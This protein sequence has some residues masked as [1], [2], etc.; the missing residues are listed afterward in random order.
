VWRGCVPWAVAWAQAALTSPQ[1]VQLGAVTAYRARR[2]PQDLL[3]LVWFFL[4][5]HARWAVKGWCWITHGDLRADARAA[6]LAGDSEVRRGA[7]EM[8][9]A[10]GHARWA[11]LGHSG[12]LGLAGGLLIAFLAGV[13][14][15]I[16]AQ[17]PREEMWPWLATLYTLLGVLA[18][19][20]GWLLKAAP[21]GWVIAAVWE[22]RDRTPGAGWLIR[23]SREDA[24]SWVDERMISQALAH[25][26]IAPLDRFV[27]NG[28]ELTYTVPA[29]VDGDGTYAQIRLPLGVEADMV[30]ARRK[31]LA[32]NLGRAALETWPTEGDEAG[33]LELWIAD[34][35]RLG[36]GAGP[37]PLLHEGSVDVFTGVPIGRTQRGQVIHGLFFERNW[38]VGGRPGQGKT[39]LVRI[40]VLGAGLDPTAEIWVFVIAQN[41]DF[42]P[43]APRLS[44]YAV[45]MGPEVAAAAVQALADLL[46]EMERRGKL[47]ATLPG[48]PPA[49]SRRLADKPALRLHPLICV[50]SECHE[51]FGHSTYGAQAAKLAISVIKQGRK[52]G[53]T[54]ILDTQSPTA[55][56]IP[57]DVT[58]HISCGIAFSVADHDANDGLLGSGK[59]RAGIRA[60]ELRM[61]TDRGTCVAVGVSDA[62]FELLN[63]F[64][65]PYTDGTDLVTP[66][67]TRAMAAIHDLRRTG[68]PT[69]GDEDQ[70]EDGSAEVDHLANIHQ[71]LR[72]ER[73]VRTQV[74]LSRLAELDP[75]TYEG[76]GFH[77]LTTT[78]ARHGIKP[79]KSRGVKSI[80]AADITHA[81]THH[82][83]HNTT[84]SDH[85]KGT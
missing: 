63:T 34:K 18:A 9:R 69:T 50:I 60:T 70:D 41:T 27:K 61:N 21:M 12:R 85:G 55:A 35:G 81:L 15:L 62:T 23:P 24:D 66:V 78:L 58:R 17:V 40:L 20:G 30:A 29:R 6:R 28:G 75:A 1:V 10:D 65:V 82:A 5:G 79:I 26:G 43:L 49:T 51:L 32:A 25:L 14:T 67:V 31:R 11:K 2:A 83:H 42:D 76:W 8:I 64:H 59:Y 54:L 68:Q 44:R 37:W 48:S 71:V 33:I 52:F 56:S 47:L 38:L 45:G 72:G 84:N 77:D 13:L 80:R 4:R 73:R 74:V 7:Q 36:K 57:T 46:T 16:D 53:I 19:L 3:R 39:S 22:G